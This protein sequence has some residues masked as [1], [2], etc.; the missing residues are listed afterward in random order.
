MPTALARKPS[1]EQ[2]GYPSVGHAMRRLT[3][4]SFTQTALVASAGLVSGGTLLSSGCS[5]SGGRPGSSDDRVRFVTTLGTQGR[6][7]YGF[8]AKSKG[9][10]ADAGIEVDIEPGQAGDYNHQMI[11]SGRAQFTVV[12]AAGALVRYGKAKDPDTSFQIIA[13]IHQSTLLSIVSLQAAGIT[14]PRSLE[15]RTLATVKGAA[16]EVLFPAYARLAE[17]DAKRITWQYGQ[18]SQLNTLVASGRV[19]GIGIFLVGKPSVEAAAKGPASELPYSDYLRD[20][21]GGVVVTQKET[22]A[23]NP[24]LVRRFTRA[25]LKGAA[26]AVDNPEEAGGILAKAVPGQDAGLAAAELKLMRNYVIPASGAPVGVIAEE[27]VV[28]SV[29]LLQGVGLLPDGSV[30]TLPRR[31]VNFDIAD[32][33]VR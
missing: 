27:R 20:L 32:G 16:P 21:F 13:A 3:R 17:I 24:D 18:A 7:A 31:V 26:Y 15:G 33:V 8:V 28:R 25:L 19:D 12:D 22:I 4:R 5:S 2:P 1:T 11:R 23:G 10:F 9:F 14:S 29:G 30:P 6:D